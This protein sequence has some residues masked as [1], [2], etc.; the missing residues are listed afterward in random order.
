MSSRSLPCGCIVGIYEA[1]SGE[2]VTIVDARG[3]SCADPAHLAGKRVPGAASDAAPP[4]RP[5]PT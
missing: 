2:I 5:E 3:A 4:A 1:Y